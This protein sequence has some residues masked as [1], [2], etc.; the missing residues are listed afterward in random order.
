MFEGDERAGG[1]IHLWIDG[2]RVHKFYLLNT[3]MYKK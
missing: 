2:F 3:G 1:G